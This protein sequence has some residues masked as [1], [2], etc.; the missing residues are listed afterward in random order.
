MDATAPYLEGPG[1]IF[2]QM[3]QLKDAD[4]AREMVAFWARRGATSFKAYMNI[5]RH[6]LGAAIE[7]AHALGL[8]VTGHLC[9]V[10]WRE[11]IAFGI[12]DLEHGPVW[13]ATDFQK[14]KRPDSCPASG[15]SAWAEQS[16][17]GA[18]EQ[19]LIRDLVAHNVAVTSTLPVFDASTLDEPP[20]PRVLQAIRSARA[21][22]PPGHG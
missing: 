22:S 9:S 20:S 1:S 19:A 5:T 12:D 11:A 8:K 2:P 17:D 16:V 10:T 18:E 21:S 6:Q 13:S 3:H 15:T 14:D 4:D 7:A